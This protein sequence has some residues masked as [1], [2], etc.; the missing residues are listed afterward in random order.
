MNTAYSP[1]QSDQ[2]NFGGFDVSPVLAIGDSV[3]GDA[4]VFTET[5]DA[6]FNLSTPYA[7]AAGDTFNGTLSTNADMDYIA[8][9]VVA[10]AT[11]MIDLTS[12]T[13]DTYLRFYDS[14]GTLFAVNDD[15]GT[16]TNSRLTLTFATSGTYYIAAGSFNN[17][18][19]GAYSVAVAEVAPLPVYTYD[20]I[21]DQLTDGYWNDTGRTTRNFAVAPGGSLDVDISALAADGQFLASAALQAW[22]YVTGITFNISTVA[23]VGEDL[24]FDDSDSGAYSSSSVSGSTINSSF[25][26][27]STA[28]LVSSG[29]TLDSYSF[30]TYI[31]E[32]G[33]AL[34]L[35]HAGNYN[36]SA[37][38]GTDNHYQND[39]WQATVMSYFSQTGNTV[40]NASFAYILTPMIADIIAI[41]NL[42]GTNSNQRTG[43]TIYGE[44]STAGGYYD[45]IAG[46]AEDV[47]MTILDNGGVDRIDLRSDTTDQIVDMRGGSIS[48]VNGLTG[49]L[50][51]ARGT[52]IENF[53]AGSGDD[54][55]NA[56]NGGNEIYGRGGSDTINGKRGA[57]R[58]LGGNGADEL[59]G[60]AG[61]DRLI[62]GRGR[63]VL[64]GASGRDVLDGNNGRDVL[65]GQDDPDQ[66]NGGAGGDW[67]YGG[68]GRDRL[69]GDAGNDKLFGGQGQDSFVFRAGH[70]AD[71]IRD[72]EDNIDTLRIDDAIWGGGLTRAQVIATYGSN[73]AGGVLL[74]FGGG[75]SIL[76]DNL[77]DKGLLQNDLVII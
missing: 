13:A 35:G 3:V 75:N 25:I 61:N 10:G 37:S 6:P 11:Y 27:V 71:R 30:Q 50:S 32:I 69:T 73:V 51:I 22:S 67:L 74:D 76:I 54:V 14:G 60:N 21:A 15:G 4:T 62:G 28:W 77:A 58:L 16:G 20:Q 18:S 39:S 19:S 53:V 41:Q 43:N 44:N 29:A 52:A 46:L 64:N 45:D 47:A 23:I 48:S 68:A 34:G 5:T 59:N 65:R 49:N 55:I 63:D 8:L 38:Y 70:G 57:D 26:N 31:H 9:T 1:P 72:F 7:I 66:L 36:G 17:A 42:Y 56:N 24:T 12:A 33:H 40:I 2:D